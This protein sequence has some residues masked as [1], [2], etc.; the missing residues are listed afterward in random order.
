[1][2]K[3][4]GLRASPACTLS[5]SRRADTRKAAV[6]S[7]PT[8]HAHS[9]SRCFSDI[10]DRPDEIS[11]TTDSA[12]VLCGCGSELAIINA[13]PTSANSLSQVWQQPRLCVLA[14]RPLH[15]WRGRRHERAERGP[16]PC[17][18]TGRI[19][20]RQGPGQTGIHVAASLGVP[21]PTRMDALLA[22]AIKDE[23]GTVKLWPCWD[24]ACKAS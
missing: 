3:A 24:R 23:F 16:E 20:H 2:S 9:V 4:S 22:A 17:I 15:T 6:R 8:R 1:M 10:S 5:S 13:V 12:C 21:F 14:T 18:I 11:D 19:Q 7:S